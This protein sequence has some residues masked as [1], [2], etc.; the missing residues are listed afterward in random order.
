M[1]RDSGVVLINALVIVLTISVLAAALLTRSERARLRA[2]YAQG[3]QQSELYLDG[4]ERLVPDLLK[5]VVKDTL[6]HTGQA[7]A[8]KGR[9]YPIDRG[10]VAVRVVDLQGRLNV[11]WLMR[12]GDFV[13]GVF[14]R[15]FT[16][17]RL[18]LTLLDEITGFVIAG[19]PKGVA[20]YMSRTPPVFPRGGP[21][22]AVDELREVRGMT[23]EYFAILAPVVSALP[24]ETRLNLNTAPKMVVEAMLQPLPDELRAELLASSAPIVAIGN[25]RKRAMELLET[26]EIEYLQLQRM[27]VGSNWFRAD[28]A[29][30]L[31]G[32]VQRRAVVFQ[33]LMGEKVTI[34]A[35]Y[36]WAVYD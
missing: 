4:V 6:S 21:L 30:S 22:R 23:P 7:W 36:R 2:S 32:A 3:A 1:R 16:E 25:I 18:P 10:Q 17:L 20:D 19:G 11:N 24:V 13:D 14:E 8:Q 34:D 27:T 33:I 28:L 29:A 31:E 35:V 5:E 9:S 26:E 15:V 12:G